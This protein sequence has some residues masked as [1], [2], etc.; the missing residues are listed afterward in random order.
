MDLS[1]LRVESL[2]PELALIDTHLAAYARDQLAV[3]RDA[4]ASAEHDPASST[5]DERAA[6]IR[7]I[8]QVAELEEFP[9]RPVSLRLPKFAAAIATWCAAVVLVA[10]E[11]IYDWSTWPL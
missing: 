9:E 3:T 10:D 1:D 5:E 8:T 7:R 4:L 6:A 2:S 11:R